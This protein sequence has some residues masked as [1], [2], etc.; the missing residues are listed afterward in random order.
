MDVVLVDRFV[1]KDFFVTWD[2][3]ETSVLEA[4]AGALPPSDF[5]LALINTHEGPVP[6]IGVVAV[7]SNV[8]IITL[9]GPARTSRHRFCVVFRNELVEGP[10]VTWHLSAE[11]LPGRRVYAFENLHGVHWYPLKKPDS[12]PVGSIPAAGTGDASPI[13]EELET[14]LPLGEDFAESAITLVSVLD[15]LNPDF[16]A[17]PRYMDLIVV[18]G[19]DRLLTWYLTEKV[20]PLRRWHSML[21]T[22]NH[23]RTDPTKARLWDTL[24]RQRREDPEF[25]KVITE[26]ESRMHNQESVGRRVTLPFTVSGAG[27]SLQATLDRLREQDREEARAWQAWEVRREHEKRLLEAARAPEGAGDMEDTEA[28]LG[29]GRGMRHCARRNSSRLRSIPRNAARGGRS[30]GRSRGRRAASLAQLW[31]STRRGTRSRSRARQRRRG[32]GL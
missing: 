5:R 1:R 31:L 30:R 28:P 13:Y 7:K 22:L 20:P 16:L 21:Q 27:E 10:R 15:L 4:L 17:I 26:A 3:L 24:V 19:N 25:V 12:I 6:I 11:P 9:L 2:A 14:I 8:V 23:I 32:L 29:G 18:T